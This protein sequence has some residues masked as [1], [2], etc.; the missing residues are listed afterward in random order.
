[1]SVRRAQQEID[2]REFA[3]WIAFGNLE[4]FGEERA[5]WRIAQLCTLVANMFRGKGRM[6]RMR[7]FMLR[8]KAPRKQTPQEIAAVMRAYTA[9][10]NAARKR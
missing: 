1:M 4:P 2:A 3:E 9:A 10:H 5:D 8:P 6:A 7:D